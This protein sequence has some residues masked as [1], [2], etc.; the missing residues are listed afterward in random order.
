MKRPSAAPP[1]ATER[2]AAWLVGLLAIGAGV[3]VAPLYYNQPILGTIAHD[4]R[5][6]P[7]E[8]GLVPMLTQLGY[9]AG[10][11]LFAPLGD[12]LDRRTVIVV[13]SA[14]LSLALVGA[15]LA[16]SVGWLAAASLLVG[17]LAT[18]AQDFVPAAAAIAPPSARGKVVGTVM[19]GLLLGILVSRLASGFA[20]ERLGWRA[21]FF[22]AAGVTAALTAASALRLPAFEPT[23]R[24][25]YRSLLASIAA[26]A[27]RSPALRRAALSQALLSVAYSGFWTTLAIAIAASPYRLGST[28]AGA[29]GLAG[30]AGALVA[31]IAGATSDRR[32]PVAVARVGAAIVLS[33]FVLMSAW[34]GALVVLVAGTILFDLGTS[35][36]LIAHQTIIYGLSPEARSRVNAVL[37]SSMFAGMAAGAALGSHAF[38]RFGW[39]GVTVVCAL[40]AAAALVARSLGVR[41][42]PSSPSA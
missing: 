7:P 16:P 28:A 22:G 36:A 6:T 30:V 2:P 4:L 13:K 40:A 17:L 41:P 26:H 21:V 39:R 34:Q 38:A 18:T 23:T 24:E 25:R 5:A 3:S 33:A 14:M 20:G 35:A 11:V 37:V 9:G 15:G 1:S 8:V 42:T 12:R 32:G 19:T 29:F 31:P 27:R 10:I